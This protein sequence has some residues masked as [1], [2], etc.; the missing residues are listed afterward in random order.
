MQSV[1]NCWHVF[2]GQY[3]FRT[4]PSVLLYFTQWLKKYMKHY[5]KISEAQIVLSIS[6]QYNACMELMV[7]LFQMMNGIC[8]QIKI[9]TWQDEKE[10]TLKQ[11]R[12][13]FWVYLGS[14][15][16]FLLE[17]RTQGW[18]L[19][20]V[21]ALWILKIWLEIIIFLHVFHM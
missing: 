18:E 1:N 3:F 15:F 16:L 17:W 13:S 5:I 4:A 7:V 2:S 19:R 10:T 20:V 21:T 9:I 14:S 8:S 6:E 12:S 11:P